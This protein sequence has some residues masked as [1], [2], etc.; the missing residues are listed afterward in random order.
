MQ[1]TQTLNEGLKRGY[2]I[3]VTAAEL[4][5]KVQAKLVEAQPDIEMKGFRKGKV[6][7]AM[8]RKQFGPRILGDAMQEAIDAGMKSHFDASGDRP[9][10]QPEVKMVGGDAWAQGQDVIVEMTYETLPAIPEVDTAALALDKLIVA[11]DDTSVD[12]ALANLANSAK[13]YGEAGRTVRE[14][15]RK[16][17]KREVTL[18]LA[19]GLAIGAAGTNVDMKELKQ[20][21]TGVDLAKAEALARPPKK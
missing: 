2:T 5:A 10:L 6:P 16:G 18:V 21:A 17:G 8:L 14:E 9:A 15:E 20:L 4:D 19:N 11:A 12:E 3:T 7:M 1:V 13:T